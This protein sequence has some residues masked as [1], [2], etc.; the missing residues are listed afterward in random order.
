TDRRMNMPRVQFALLLSLLA[1]GCGAGGRIDPATPAATD[2]SAS[3]D[4]RAGSDCRADEVCLIA[5]GDEG[6]CTRKVESASQ[7]SGQYFHDESGAVGGVCM[8]SAPGTVT[9]DAL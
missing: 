5:T 6:Q 4:C 1:V 7:C 8:P 3:R 2:T 9:P